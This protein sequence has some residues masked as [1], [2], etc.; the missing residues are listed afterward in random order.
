MALSS[1]FFDF[2]KSGK[3]IKVERLTPKDFLIKRTKY[4]YR[5]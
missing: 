3:K 5:W 1:I 4:D 2:D